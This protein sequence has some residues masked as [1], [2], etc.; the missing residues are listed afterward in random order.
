MSDKPKRK[1]PDWE[2]IEREYR[3]GQLSVRQIAANFGISHTAIQ[4]RVS[5]GGWE[6]DLTEKVQKAVAR[7]IVASAV[8]TAS[9]REKMATEREIVKAASDR[10]AQV[11]QGHLARAARLAK[12]ADRNLECLEALQAGQPLPFDFQ[13]GKGDCTTTLIKTTADLVERSAN[14]ERKALNLDAQ[15]PDEDTTI[16]VKKY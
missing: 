5:A 15:T 2:A 7:K 8:A 4:K 9:P 3:A 13:T 11:I 14:M 6:Q 10:G 12:I 1:A 16:I